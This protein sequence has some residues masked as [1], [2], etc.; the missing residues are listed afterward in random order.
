[1]RLF[2]NN[3][4]MVYLNSLKT[5][6]KELFDTIPDDIL[7]YK[8]YHYGSNY[9]MQKHLPDVM[10]HI[11]NTIFQR[12]YINIFSSKVVD[13]YLSK[14]G[15]LQFFNELIFQ[16]EENGQLL[17]I[18]SNA[19]K[20]LG[21]VY[22]LDPNCDIDESIIKEDIIEYV[23]YLKQIHP[24]RI[25]KAIEKVLSGNITSLVRGNHSPF[26]LEHIFSDDRVQ[27]IIGKNS[28][29]FANI[30]T[31]CGKSDILKYTK[32]YMKFRDS[33]EECWIQYID[34][35]KYVRFSDTFNDQMF[36]TLQG[37]D[38]LGSDCVDY[39]WACL[40][41]CSCLDNCIK[42]NKGYIIEFMKDMGL[43]D[44]TMLE[45]KTFTETVYISNN[46]ILG[47]FEKYLNTHYRIFAPLPLEKRTDCPITNKLLQKQFFVLAE[48]DIATAERV[49]SKGR[50]QRTLFHSY[51]Q[52]HYLFV[53]IFHVL[54]KKNRFDILML[55]IKKLAN[56]EWWKSLSSYRWVQ[57]FFDNGFIDENMS[58]Y[59][60][61]IHFCYAYDDACILTTL[62][63]SEYISDNELINMHDSLLNC[64]VILEMEGVGL[65]F[66]DYDEYTGDFYRALTDIA[67][68]IIT[69]RPRYAAYLACMGLS[70]FSYTSPLLMQSTEPYKF[71]YDGSIPEFFIK[72][73]YKM[74]SSWEIR[75]AYRQEY[76]SIF[77]IYTMI[78]NRF[79]INVNF[80]NVFHSRELLIIII[81]YLLDEYYY[82]LFMKH[83]IGTTTTA[84]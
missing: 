57:K 30:M 35:K 36:L 77:T 23:N 55:I 27:Y 15:I 44:Y 16:K 48:V 13:W 80:S 79:I 51:Y 73:I 18:S 76:N 64:G 67:K 56:R 7:F 42:P 60:D 3:I 10:R 84:V 8:N 1:M 4:E 49:M 12:S 20:E 14:L 59:D 34:G 45:I 71:I 65:Q 46:V 29:Q 25:W 21:L 24:R 6:K 11:I 53:S 19:I 66:Y 38:F 83:F 68:Y 5:I 82:P 9:N 78:Y 54:V 58:N 74:T 63:K 43:S 31:L 37:Y 26:E 33:I 40:D 62:I 70:E 52:N 69:N 81:S 61:E 75:M 47:Q 22:I 32:Y 17:T 2:L 50:I 28:N 39:E 72:D 41:K